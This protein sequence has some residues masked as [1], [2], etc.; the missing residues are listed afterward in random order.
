M[1][2]L[3]SQRREAAEEGKEGGEPVRGSASS[4]GEWGV[5]LE[6]QGLRVG[7]AWGPRLTWSQES[8]AE[9]A[10]GRS[11]LVRLKWHPGLA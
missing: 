2:H 11:G 3:L 7:G 10:A 5:Q 4:L 6:A 9:S 8:G 1:K